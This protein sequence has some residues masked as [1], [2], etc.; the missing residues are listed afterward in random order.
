MT[1]RRETRGP[2]HAGLPGRAAVSRDRGEEVFVLEAVWRMDLT[3]DWAENS[4]RMTTDFR[5]T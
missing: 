1:Q 4:V 3:K 2:D 5:N